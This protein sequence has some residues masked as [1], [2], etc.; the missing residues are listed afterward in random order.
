MV[1]LRSRNISIRENGLFSGQENRNGKLIRENGQ[2]SGRENRNGKPIW[3][4]GQFSGQENR[5]GKPI[6][7]NGLFS[8]QE[9]WDGAWNDRIEKDTKGICIY[10]MKIRFVHQLRCREQERFQ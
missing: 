2:F 6:R 3:G 5:T 8:G 7:G 9:S 10:E 1:I 4:N